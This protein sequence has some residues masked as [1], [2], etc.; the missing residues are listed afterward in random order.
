MIITRLALKQIYAVHRR[1]IT[2]ASQTGD[3]EMGGGQPGR[4][5]K[6]RKC[7]HQRFQASK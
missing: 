3:V 2:A 1:V 4:E 5:L 6:A 7:T